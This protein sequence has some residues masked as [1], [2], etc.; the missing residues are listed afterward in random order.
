MN[1]Q[2]DSVDELPPTA[3]A[4]IARRKLSHEVLDRLLANIR[5][6]QFP[7][8]ALLPS[9]RELMASFGV[10]RPA[11][12]EA[13]QA[14][15]RM[16]LVAIV[17]GEGARVLPLSA[18]SVIAQLS[19]SVVHL[20]SGNQ[21]LLEHLKEARI[22]FEVG[23]VR[24]AA[25]RATAQDIATLRAALDRHLASRDDAARFL[26]T[27]LAF[28]NAI[29]AVSGNPVYSAVSHAMLQWLERFHVDLVRAPGAE[30][31]SLDEH[32][33]IFECIAAHDADGAAKAVVEHLRRANASYPAAAAQRSLR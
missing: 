32:V 6:G 31:V 24:L 11:V 5:A 20:L 14:L 23:M 10:G 22:A 21:G 30:P 16:G 18:D 17:H 28:H 12:R 2:R 7:V 33:R 3:P 4:P 25:T 8:G 26:E 27:D 19:E 9:E 29:A 15:E 1:R 13:L